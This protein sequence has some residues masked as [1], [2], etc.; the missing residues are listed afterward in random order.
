MANFADLLSQQP[1]LL[2][3]VP[4][5]A[6]AHYQ[7]AEQSAEQHAADGEDEVANVENVRGDEHR[8]EPGVGGDEEEEVEEEDDRQDKSCKKILIK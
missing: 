7:L 1:I 4:A 3:Q 8:P 5:D 2:V 6:D